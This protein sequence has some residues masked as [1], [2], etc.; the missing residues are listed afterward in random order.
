MELNQIMMLV[1]MVVTWVLGIVSKK[2]NWV[3]NNLIPLQ[4]LAIGL[5]VAGVEWIITGNFSTAIA[6]S[7]IGAGGTYDL[8]HNLAK[9]KNDRNEEIGV[10]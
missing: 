7:G 2:S 8:F 5:I 9:L 6:L 4:N 1:T 10:G 3:N